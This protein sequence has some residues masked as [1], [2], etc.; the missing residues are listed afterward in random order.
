[1]NSKELM[2]MISSQYVNTRNRIICRKLMQFLEI[3]RSMEKVVVLR[4][5]PL[6]HTILKDYNLKFTINLNSIVIE[7]ECQSL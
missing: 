4:I 6:D 5:V 7:K 1:M 2:K 3:R